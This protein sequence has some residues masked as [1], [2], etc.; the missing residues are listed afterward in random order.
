M[1]P[2][3]PEL[4]LLSTRMFPEQNRII[5]FG[6]EFARKVISMRVND[7]TGGNPCIDIAGLKLGP[8]LVGKLVGTASEFIREPHHVKD[9]VGDFHLLLTESGLGYTHQAGHDP[10]SPFKVQ[11]LLTSPVV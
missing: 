11:V 5:A 1:F 7:L 10:T 8:I 6:E 4:L 9:G 2:A 3:W